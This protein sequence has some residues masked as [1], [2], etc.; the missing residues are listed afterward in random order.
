MLE[1]LDKILAGFEND[2]EVKVI[3]WN[4]SNGNLKSQ[5][6]DDSNRTKKSLK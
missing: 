3:L 6:F 1:D 4:T 2:P 5:G